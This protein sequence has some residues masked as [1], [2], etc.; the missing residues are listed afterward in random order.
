MA[1]SGAL[2][3]MDDA[4]NDYLS[5]SQSCVR[6]V[7]S[8][9]AP[10]VE[11]STTEQSGGASIEID[12]PEG[13]ISST[14][15]APSKEIAAPAALSLED[16]LAC[17]GCVTSSESILIGLQGVEELRKAVANKGLTEGPTHLVAS[18]SPQSLASLSARYRISPKKV[19]ER[20][21]EYLKTRLNFDVVMDTT[22]ARHISLEEQAREYLER[23]QQSKIGDD[24]PSLPMLASACPGWICYAEKTHGELLPLISRT[25]S[26]QQIA[27]LLAKRY[28]IESQSD[29]SPRVYHTTIMPCYDKKLEASRQDFFDDVLNARDVDLV[30]TTGEIDDMM[31][32]D[33]FDLTEGDRM[34]EDIHLPLTPPQSDQGDQQISRQIPSLL[35]Q[36]GSSS[37]SYL[38]DLIRRTWIDHL[39]QMDI[40]EGN[41]QHLPS[42]SVRTVRSADYTEYVLR[43]SAKQGSEILFKGA[44]CYGFRNLQNLVRKVQKQTGIKSKKSSAAR[45]GGE[46]GLLLA[47]RRGGRG[48]GRGSMVRRGAR[49]GV[50]GEGRVISQEEEEE[51][52]I[53]DFV[54]VMACPGGCVNGGGQIRPPGKVADTTTSSLTTRTII[55]DVTESI[56]EGVSKSNIVENK[57][58]TSLDPEGFSEGWM[59]P[60][61][62]SIGDDVE[63][64]GVQ[65]EEEIEEPEMTGWKGTTKE[66]VKQVEKMYWQQGKGVDGGVTSVHHGQ[67]LGWPKE[68]ITKEIQSTLVKIIDQTR[69]QSSSHIDSLAKMVVKEMSQSRGRVED[70][71]TLL[72]TQYRAIQDDAV[73]GLAVQW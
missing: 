66:W 65:Q 48:A 3:L 23:K 71:R 52:R 73:S 41:Q 61:A 12:T 56:V 31:R 9:N 24:G 34:E 67:A 19:L 2:S 28:I 37:G 44:Q 35:Q 45:V 50:Q 5:P 64:L 47:G 13:V 7:T 53:Y 14:V 29:E 72:R 18:I 59:T 20:V 38:F 33:D 27:G 63:M 49:G 40:E 69:G 15:S 70:R 32:A 26:P 22:F 17:S 51:D 62:S 8:T 39:S 16:C 21:D 11:E 4:L 6:A 46:G 43:T 1:F 58:K 55:A 60:A 42:L 25:R 30:I 54:E 10:T 57:L 68:R 36:Q